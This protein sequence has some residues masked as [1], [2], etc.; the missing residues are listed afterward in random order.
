MGHVQKKNPYEKN[1]I[2]QGR[3]HGKI[4]YSGEKLKTERDCKGKKAEHT[5][6]TL[7]TMSDVPKYAG[8]IG[9]VAGSRGRNYTL[10]TRTGA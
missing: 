7:F 10:G 2:Q 4:L 1:A 9:K 5:A 6:N 3:I 8:D